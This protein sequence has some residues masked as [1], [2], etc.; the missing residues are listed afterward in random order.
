MCTEVVGYTRAK[1]LQLNAVGDGRQF[2]AGVLS[3]RIQGNLILDHRKC[4]I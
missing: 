1:S 4:A 3:A 2:A